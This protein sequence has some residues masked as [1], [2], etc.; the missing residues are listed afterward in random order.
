MTTKPFVGF[1]LNCPLPTIFVVDPGFISS[2][3]PTKP[4][5]IDPSG[6]PEG[7]IVHIRHCAVSP[8]IALNGVGCGA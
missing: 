6:K 2:R 8:E 7:N 5:T 1:L 3:V 4:K